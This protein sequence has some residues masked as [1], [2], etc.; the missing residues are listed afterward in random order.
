MDRRKKYLRFLAFVPAIVLV[1]GFIG[2]RAGAFELFP[3]P[4]PQPESQPD[5][6]PTTSPH[7]PATQLAPESDPTY[8]PGSKFIRIDIPP[9]SWATPTGSP[10]PGAKPPSPP[11]EKPPTF[12]LGS[13]SAPI[14]GVVEGLTPPVDP[15]K[16][17][18]NGLPG[19]LPKP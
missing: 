3:K 6:Q 13:K 8:M 4:E 18:P 5:P 10:P 1:G 15:P 19:V 2:H 9:P 7:P 16:P 14:S 17:N 11:P 12:M